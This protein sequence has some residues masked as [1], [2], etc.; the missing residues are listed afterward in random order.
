MDPKDHVY[1]ATVWLLVIWTVLHAFSGVIMQLYCIARRAAG[2]M[3]VRH[4]IDIQN[5]ALY[6]HFMAI[7]VTVAIAVIAGF[8]LLRWRTPPRIF[9]LRTGRV[10]GCLPFRRRFGR[11]FWQATLP[12]QSGTGCSGAD[13]HRHYRTCRLA[14]T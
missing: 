1:S 2:R 9:S 6:W 7:T 11:I 8:P 3:T 5:V 10:S 12:L 14:Q 13:W 4:D